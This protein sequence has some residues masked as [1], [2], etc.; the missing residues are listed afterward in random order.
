VAIS[1][2]VRGYVPLSTS[3]RA[4]DTHR[5][6]SSFRKR[7]LAASLY[8]EGIK[9]KD[10]IAV[11]QC[12][13]IAKRGCRSMQNSRLLCYLLAST[14]SNLAAPTVIRELMQITE[15]LTNSMASF[16]VQSSGEVTA[17]IRQHFIRYFYGREACFTSQTNR[18]IFKSTSTAERGSGI[19]LV[20]L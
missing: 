9:R 6:Y 10:C 4:L 16:W 1:Q 8:P 18:G 17:R 15:D 7:G 2:C 19:S 20:S 3:S 12:Q 5:I 13:G 14:Q 11:H